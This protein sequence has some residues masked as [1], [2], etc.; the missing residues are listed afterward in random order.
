MTTRE[1]KVK[2]F[3]DAGNKLDF[4]DS[5]DEAEMIMGCIYEEFL[6]FDEAALVY[7]SAIDNGMVRNYPDQME[8]IRGQLCKEWADLQYVV[9]QAAL[10][11][12][13]PADRAFDRVHESNMTKVV[14]GKLILRDDGKILK[15]DSYQAPDMKGL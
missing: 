1:D 9:S 4:K 10:Y 11:Y 13:I 14:D 2:E 5:P 3:R 12:N 6:E 15:P 7:E 8:E